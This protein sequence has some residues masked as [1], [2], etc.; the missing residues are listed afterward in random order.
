VFNDDGNWV[1]EWI[2]L[3]EDALQSAAM[4][5]VEVHSPRWIGGLVSFWLLAGASILLVLGLVSC[6][7]EA[8]VAAPAQTSA[9]CMECHKEIHTA[10][11]GTDHALA[12]H[13]VGPSDA[14]VLASF[15]E[16]D[17]TRPAVAI[18]GNKP[19]WQPLIPAEGGRLQPHEIAYDPAKHEWFNVF[20]DENRRPGEW[21][22]WTG[23]GM[24]WNSMCAHCHTTDF[25][26]RYDVATDTFS[27]K[28][29]EQGIGCV[30]CHGHVTA[31]HV[32]PG[33]TSPEKP[34]LPVARAAAMETC[35]P[36]HARNEILARGFTPGDRYSDFYRITLPVNPEVFWPDGQQRDEDFNWTSVL[37]S[38]MAHAGVTCMDCHDAHSTRT[39]LPAANN[40]ICMQCHA[41]PGRIQ[42][43]GL[44]VPA[45]DPLAHSHHKEDSAGNLCVEC[46]MPKA[47][48]MQRAPRHDHGWL[49]P[50]P[51]L[52][53]E[54]GIPNAC[55]PCHTDKDVDWEIRYSEEWYGDKL[56]TRQRAR[57]RAVAAAQTGD[58]TAVGK[59]LSLLANEDIPA[60]RATFLQLLGLQPH[61]DP[62]IA[63]AGREALE[64]ADPLVRASGVQILTGDPEARAALRPLLKDP[65]RLVRLDTAWAL[66]DELA[67]DSAERREFDLYLNE[68]ADQPGGQLRIGQDLANRGHLAEALS[69]METAVAWDP[70]SPGILDAQAMVLS[71]MGKPREA[72]AAF[73]RAGQLNPHDYE[74]MFRA[75]LTY[76][77]AGMIQEATVSLEASVRR[78]PGFD[79]GWYNLGL[80]RAQSGDLDG[81]IT[82]LGRA[83]AA[84]P[85]VADYPFAAATVLLRAGR[86]IEAKEAARRALEIDPA[87]RDAARLLG[88][89]GK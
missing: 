88:S 72:A 25:E 67:P 12:N 6:S 77:E 27:S 34:L 45:I 59:V 82:A 89:E 29:L 11:S 17:A 85:G 5:R 46:H 20:G 38:R 51:I 4:E 76:A 80:L 58:P 44:Q 84:A 75:G 35:A 54:L 21:G 18:L 32:V 65:S 3:S 63:A 73:F 70:Y 40:M 74:A 14:A 1:Q 79:R 31:A 16:A 66:A 26:K 50:D 13:V 62:R 83:E 41:A 53:K 30:Q 56:D 10:W 9:S 39:I 8:H 23:R 36:C 69:H 42:P 60:W 61:G 37:L 28:W 57:A 49:K 86:V 68:H 2:G 48:Y 81:A 24:N 55:T 22:H 78:N 52:T 7:R 15:P 87:H 43:S 71:T 19:L 47:T 33:Y 64:D